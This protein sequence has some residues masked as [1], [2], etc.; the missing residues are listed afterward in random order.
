M[1]QILGLHVQGAEITP[2][3][4]IPNKLIGKWY[5]RIKN[6]YNAEQNQEQKTAAVLA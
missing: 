5:D 6:R 2:I 4:D 3:L 1:T